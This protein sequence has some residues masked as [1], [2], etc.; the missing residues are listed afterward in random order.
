MSIAKVTPELLGGSVIAVPPLARNADYSLSREGNRRI[1][2]HLAAGGVTTALYGGNANLYNVGVREFDALLTQ[3]EEVAPPGTWIIPSIGPDY[4]KAEDQVDVL[5]SRD[6]PTAMVLPLT[7]PTTS[8]GVATGLR[9]LADRY[10]RPLI[11]Y[12]K[13]E[14]FI[15]AADLAKLVADGAVCTI[16]YAIART[17]TATDRYLDE[18]LAG[19]ERSRIVSGMGERPAVTHLTNQR[20][21]GFTSGSVCIAPAMSQAMLAALKDGDAAAAGALREK[22]LPLEDLRDAHS[23]LRVLHA[24][25][26]AA[27]VAETGP[28]QPFL[29]TIEDPAILSRIAAAA[30]TLLGHEEAHRAARA[31]A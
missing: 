12:V 21:Q 5:K 16:K 13:S 1:L 27:G 31:A 18:L 6:L 22:F 8:D 30:K 24:A 15:S 17:D 4:G 25:V 28:M 14:T 7:F 11:A 20:L 2:A 29:S 3:L 23:Q 9:R 10:G 26:A 19:V